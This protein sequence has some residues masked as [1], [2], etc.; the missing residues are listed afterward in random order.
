MIESSTLLDS[1]SKIVVIW[2]LNF[3]DNSSK[4]SSLINELSTSRINFEGFLFFC[5]F[6]FFFFTNSLNDYSVI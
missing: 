4:I 2:R 6:V 1:Y 5:F 3:L